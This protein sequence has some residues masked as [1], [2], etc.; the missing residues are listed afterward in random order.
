[1]L[2]KPCHSCAQPVYHAE[3]VLAGGKVYHNACFLCNVCNK[4][5]DSRSLNEHNNMI[6]CNFCYK[7]FFGPSG[8]GF[9]SLQL[10]KQ[11]NTVN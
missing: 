3:Q 4:R 2:I 11:N 9:G 7:E 5:L 1:M 8:Y 6:Y 10:R